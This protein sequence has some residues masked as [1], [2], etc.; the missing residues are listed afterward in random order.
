MDL[1]ILWN[2]QDTITTFLDIIYIPV[3]KLAEAFPPLY[4]LFFSM[5]IFVFFIINFPKD[6]LKVFA[7]IAMAYFF[8]A[9]YLLLQLTLGNL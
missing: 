4:L 3:Y 8:G 2:L 7:I 5:F 6:W 1:E 9:A